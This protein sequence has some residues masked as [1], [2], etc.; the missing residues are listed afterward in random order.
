MSVWAKAHPVKA[1]GVY[2]TGDK[3]AGGFFDED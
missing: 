3:V 1:K 2:L